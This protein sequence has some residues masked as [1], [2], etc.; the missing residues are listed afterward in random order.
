MLQ[1]IQQ[2]N[3]YQGECEFTKLC[4]DFVLFE[5]SSVALMGLKP[6]LIIHTRTHYTHKRTIILSYA[7]L[8]PLTHYYTLKHTLVTT[9]C[10]FSWREKDK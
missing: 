2:R 6:S 1:F 5:T 8:C 4:F 10:P 9:S 3:L 7:P